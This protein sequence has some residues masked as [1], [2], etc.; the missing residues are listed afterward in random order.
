MS[1]VSEGADRGGRQRRTPGISASQQL[2]ETLRHRILHFHLPPGAGIVKRD[3][4]AEFAVSP[5]PVRE[6][7]LRLADEGLV[8]VYPQSGTFVSLIDVQQAREVHFLRLA[9]EIEVVRTLCANSGP[10]GTAELQRWIRRQEMEFEAGDKTAFAIADNRFHDT[11][12]RLAGVQGLTQLIESR[13]GHF[14][15]IRGLYLIENDRRRLVIDEHRAIL[16]A[17]AARDAVAAEAAIRMHIGKS[18]IIID[19][20][21]AAFPSYFL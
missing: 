8:D 4:S 6:A 3:L 1:Q 18:L 12:F 7:L 20:I 13:R 10:E 19:E 14:D 16:E 9:V 21:R 11:M 17:L 5:T 2:Y 15:R